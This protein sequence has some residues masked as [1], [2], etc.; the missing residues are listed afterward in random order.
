MAF[1]LSSRES[2]PALTLSHCVCLFL[3]LLSIGLSCL[4]LR[5]KN[6][7]P[8]FVAHPLFF[9]C[10]ADVGLIVRAPPGLCLWRGWLCAR[11][12]RA[13]HASCAARFP[14]FRAHSR[15]SGGPAPPVPSGATLRRCTPAPSVPFSATLRRCAPATALRPV[16]RAAPLRGTRFL[17]LSPLGVCAAFLPLRA[18]AHLRGAWPGRA[19]RFLLARAR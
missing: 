19:S 15:R 4:S 3:L 13:A 8:P 5:L 7:Q 2:I 12:A 14:F 6:V 11:R 1:R 17:C 9:R 10:A 16:L 18:P